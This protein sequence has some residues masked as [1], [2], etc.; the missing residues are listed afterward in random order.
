M[1]KLSA[2]VFVLLLAGAAMASAQA[3]PGKF[4]L[5]MS[6][7]YYNLKFDDKA[8]S[9]SYLSLPVRFG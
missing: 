9:L 8:G 4:E 7:S 6:V 2:I 1:K 3:L 5:G